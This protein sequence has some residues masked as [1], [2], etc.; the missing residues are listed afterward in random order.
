MVVQPS[1]VEFPDEGEHGEQ[2][3]LARRSIVVEFFPRAQR[4]FDDVESGRDYGV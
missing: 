1:R 2:Q 4:L 3:G